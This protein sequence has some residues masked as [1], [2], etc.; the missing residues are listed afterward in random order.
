MKYSIAQKMTRRLML[1]LILSMIIIYVG[2]FFFISDTLKTNN[3]KYTDTMASFYADVICEN[4]QKAGI[5]IDM[6]HL[7]E[8]IATSEYMCTWYNI[9]CA[10][11]YS[12]NLDEGTITYLYVTYTR[13]PERQLMEISDLQGI[14]LDYVLND[15]ERLV[16]AGEKLHAHISSDSIFGREIGS[17]ALLTDMYGH[18]YIAGIDGSYNSLF[19]DIVKRF[20]FI[21]LV[22]AVVIVVIFLVLREMM[23][24][25][26]GRPAEL[27][28][29]TMSEYIKDGK[30][31]DSKL[32]IE[33]GGEYS[34]IADSFNSMTENID[35]YVEDIKTLNADKAERKAQLDI[36][37][38]IQKGLLKGP[39]YASTGC[40]ISAM[41]EPARDIGG[42]LYDYIPLGDGKMLL[43]IAD[44]SGKGISASL[45]M[46]VI[47]TLFRQYAK[48]GMSPS[49][50]LEKANDS[51]SENN[52]SLLFA[53]VFV[54]VYDSATR[55]VTYSNAGHNV[56]YVAGK[57]LIKLDKADGTLLG[58]FENETYTEATV[59]LEIG[60]TLFLYTDGVTEAVNENKEF[61]GTQRLEKALTERENYGDDPVPYIYGEISDFSNGAERHDDITMLTLTAKEN[62]L[63]LLLDYDIKDIAKIKEELLAL[64]ISRHKQLS[65]CLAAEEIFVNIV[66]YAFDGKAPEG[67][68]ICFTISVSDKIVMTFEDGGAKFDPLE[69][70]ESP[71]DYD[72]DNQIGGLGRFIAVNNVDEMKYDY[73]NGKNVLTITDYLK[74]D[75]E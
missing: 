31:S 9:D 63:E 1:V 33:G 8:V 47:L 49:E 50:M 38:R 28:S 56:P 68:K 10:Y 32:V 74:E 25:R 14:T 30:K 15:E 23:K 62:S 72:I 36:A 37:S 48:L 45:F 43:V 6:E 55:T 57:E 18:K 17:I 66:S 41:M 42:D 4:S 51:L 58:L 59:K 54:A 16:Y 75:K 46:T 70:V 53:T 22:I 13:D 27:I 24:R 35:K 52:P 3:Q 65:L 60:D 34:M 73:I 5:P 2:L 71:D 26:V 12:P 19:R 7:D 29:R 61:F 69:F 44:V 40:K 11:V 21:A 20:V 64:P 39:E 67:E